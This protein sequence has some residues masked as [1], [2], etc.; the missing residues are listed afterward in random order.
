MRED[1]SACI[2]V[3]ILGPITEENQVNFLDIRLVLKELD[4]L[5]KWEQHMNITVLPHIRLLPQY[6]DGILLYRY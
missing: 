3:L 4:L 6:H 2:K 1:Y 5:Q